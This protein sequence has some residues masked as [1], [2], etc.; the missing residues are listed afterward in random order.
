MHGEPLNIQWKRNEFNTYYALMKIRVGGKDELTIGAGDEF[1]Y[2]G[3]IL[4]YAG[5]EIP[6]HSLR[7]M[8]K[9][10]WVSDSPPDGDERALVR[11]HQA[12]RNVAKSQSVNK[13]L[14]HVA[15]GGARAVSLDNL[16]E[17]TVFEVSDRSYVRDNRSQK[18]H[19]TRE[20]VRDVHNQ[21]IAS[22]RGM[23]IEDSVQDQG[24][25]EVGRVRTSTHL[26]ADVLDPR[27]R[28]L[29]DQLENLS[30]SGLIRDQFSPVV[31]RHDPRPTRK[32]IHTEGISISTNVGNV[33]RQVREEAS[34]SGVEVGRVRHSSKSSRSAEGGV[35]ISDTSNIRAE[36]AAAKVP[37]VKTYK[38]DTKVSPQ[39]RVARAIDPT[40]P[41]NWSFSG[42]LSERLAA[43]KARKGITPE[44]LD[45]LYAAEGD[46]MRRTLAKAYPDQFGG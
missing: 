6:Q 2:D 28:G 20:N 8:F 24:G 34:E 22:A 43:V 7:G 5:A 35:E 41:A 29:K 30:G 17:D 3:S 42:R 21:R 26:K 32:L 23:S 40:F 37:A 1:Q 10:G 33:D 13:D 46:A 15:R 9:Q 14:A 4:K 27:N 44:F 16:D 11:P 45:A 36:R 31:E 38:V 19:L 18:G 25:V 39:V 12:M